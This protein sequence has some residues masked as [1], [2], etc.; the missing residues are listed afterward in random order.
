MSYLDT[1]Q[2]PKD[3]RPLGLP[4]LKELAAE[5]RQVILDTVAKNGGHLA[6]S[7]GAVELAIGLHHAYQTPRDKIIWDVGHQGYPHKL[8]TGR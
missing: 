1:L 5:I 6:S 3:I 4:Q 2:S 8:L 7:L